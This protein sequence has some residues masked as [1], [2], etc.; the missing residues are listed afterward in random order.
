MSEAARAHHDLGGTARFLCESID[1]EA[2][3]LTAFDR[4]VDAI[5]GI[6]VLQLELRVTPVRR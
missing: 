1:T 3:A 5:R 2:H 4:E 6:L